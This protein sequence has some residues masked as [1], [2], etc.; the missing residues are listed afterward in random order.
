GDTL[1]LQCRK[2]ALA[3]SHDG[4]LLASHV[5]D[6]MT[7]QEWIQLWD[8]P[9]GTHADRLPAEPEEEITALAFSPD[10]RVLAAVVAK[11]VRLYDLAARG[12][13]RTLESKAAVSRISFRPDGKALACAAGK[14]VFVWDV[15]A[16][17]VTAT[18]GEHKANVTALA[19]SPDGRFL[20][21]ADKD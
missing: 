1:A 12:P 11:E 19:Y 7:D 20:A 17:K 3:G 16:G 14:S 13:K 2:G 8:L 9:D 15:A 4:R 6:W 21:S 5:K 10:D 18:L